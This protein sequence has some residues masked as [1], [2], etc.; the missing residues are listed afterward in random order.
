MEAPELLS[1]RASADADGRGGKGQVETCSRTGGGTGIG[2][3]GRAVG[4]RPV[5]WEDACV[6]TW[7]AGGHWYKM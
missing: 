4:G 7:A 6:P 5:S 1:N 2:L 3:P